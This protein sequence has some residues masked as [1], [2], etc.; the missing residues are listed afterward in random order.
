MNRQIKYSDDKIT[1]KNHTRFFSQKV[2][3]LKDGQVAIKK[4]ERIKLLSKVYQFEIQ[5]KL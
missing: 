1:E 2:I 4:V 5:G 3:W